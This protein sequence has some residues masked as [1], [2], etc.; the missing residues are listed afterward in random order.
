MWSIFVKL[1][2]F[3]RTII[4]SFLRKN[5]QTRTNSELQLH[6]FRM[7]GTVKL[8]NRN[9]LQFITGN[10]HISLYSNMCKKK[11]LINF[12]NNVSVKLTLVGDKLVPYSLR[13]T[14]DGLE[15][16][17]QQWT[18]PSGP[19]LGNSWQRWWDWISARRTTTQEETLRVNY[20]WR[21]YSHNLFNNWIEFM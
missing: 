4:S 20:T 13:Q 3:L 15:E 6:K 9:G 16:A 21:M 1:S 12:S 5:P 7:Y 19:A 18:T 11:L 14:G 2:K 10:I 17:R 8:F